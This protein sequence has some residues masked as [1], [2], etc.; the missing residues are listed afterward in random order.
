M[1]IVKSCAKTRFIHV[2]IASPES[3]SIRLEKA[4]WCQATVV[5]RSGGD[6]PCLE[7]TQ[8]DRAAA[9]STIV[10]STQSRLCDGLCEHCSRT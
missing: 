6:E 7:K 2:T 5:L 8:P 1:H 9:E 10:A 4:T 3:K